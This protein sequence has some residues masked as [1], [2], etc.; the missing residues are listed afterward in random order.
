MIMLPIYN[1]SNTITA[2]YTQTPSWDLLKIERPEDKLSFLQQ[3]KDNCMDK[4]I[5]KYNTQKA[6]LDTDIK[7]TTP[8]GVIVG[9]NIIEETYSIRFFCLLF[10]LCEL[11]FYQENLDDTNSPIEFDS[12]S[13][14]FDKKKIQELFDANAKYTDI[15]ERYKE[16]K[17]TIESEGKEE[18]D[19]GDNNE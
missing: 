17:E 9:A 12:I 10:A 5:L 1:I 18:R 8:I 7:K 16:Y 14:F 13:M 2:T 3:M 15:I 6:Y 19:V 4:P 11:N